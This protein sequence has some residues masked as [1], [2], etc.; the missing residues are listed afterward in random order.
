MGIDRHRR[1]QDYVTVQ[2][3]AEHFGFPV[4]R[5]YRAIKRGL[6]KSYRF[7]SGRILVRLS[8]IAALLEASAQGGA[9]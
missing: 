2:V 6:L 1:D 4:W 3:A 8:D 7:A 5:I 9:R